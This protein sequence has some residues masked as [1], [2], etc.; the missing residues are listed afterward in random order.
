VKLGR[1]LNDLDETQKRDV[2]VLGDE[3]SHNL[4]PGR[5]AIGS[6]I[7]LN[8][9]RFEVVGTLNRVGHGDDNSTN[10]RA[11]IPFQ[12]MRSDFPLK[13]RRRTTRFRASTI[14]PA[15]PTNTPSPRTRRAGSSP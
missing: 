9:H 6:F 10:T 15:S 11:Y 2:V 1:W 12:V 8:G 7:L 13:V 3:M 14:S 4:F 5:P